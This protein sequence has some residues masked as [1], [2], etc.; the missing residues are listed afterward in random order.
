MPTTDTPDYR[1]GGIVNMA[2][3]GFTGSGAAV[4]VTLG[5][6]PKYVKVFNE[7]D[8]TTWEW[9]KGMAATIAFKTVTAGTMTAD[10]GSAIVDNDDGTFTIS[11]TAAANNKVLTWVAYA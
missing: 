9:V 8:A 6:K 10:T 1:S 7:T 4:V 11:A 2:Q 3:G 5:F